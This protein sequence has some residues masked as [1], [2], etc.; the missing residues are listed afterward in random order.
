MK[1]EIY[2]NDELFEIKNITF[3]ERF[4]EGLF[5]RKDILSNT[6]IDF[7]SIGL[8]KGDK[9]VLEVAFQNIKKESLD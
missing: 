7:S 1:I 5:I 8:L 3:M 2:E 6:E 4:R 9:N